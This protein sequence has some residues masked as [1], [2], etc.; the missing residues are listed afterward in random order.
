MTKMDTH[1]FHCSTYILVIGWSSCIMMAFGPKEL[2]GMGVFDK[3]VDHCFAQGTV[4]NMM[5]IELWQLQLESGLRLHILEHPEE[6]MPYLTE[7]WIT[8]MRK[9]MVENQLQLTVARAKVA[10]KC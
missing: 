4:E 6:W 10:H 9:F 1:I 8:S 5:M 2:G 3:S 7:S